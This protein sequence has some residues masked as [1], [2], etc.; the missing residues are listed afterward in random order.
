MP[1]KVQCPVCGTPLPVEGR[2][3][4]LSCSGCGSVLEIAVSPALATLGELDEELAL[5]PTQI[6]VARPVEMEEL[7]SLAGLAA[8]VTPHSGPLATPDAETVVM[9]SAAEKAA[10]AA[11]RHRLEEE[12]AAMQDALRR[13]ETELAKHPRPTA[14]PEPQPQFDDDAARRYEEDARR[15]L[16]AEIE[17]LEQDSRGR[18]LQPT[19]DLDE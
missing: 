14:P 1:I 13:L 9:D 6:K 2:S 10:L 17:R 16:L 7:P 5:D 11:T 3:G 15:Q 12:A 4:Q 8:G 18:G 19:D